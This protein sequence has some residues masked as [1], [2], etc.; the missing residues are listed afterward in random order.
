MRE[1]GA[2][3][4]APWG[5]GSKAASCVLRGLSLSCFHCCPSS[6]GPQARKSARVM[7]TVHGYTTRLCHGKASGHASL[8]P[9]HV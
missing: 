3:L 2:V 9:M 8:C 4:P 7:P 6:R 5:Q 1:A